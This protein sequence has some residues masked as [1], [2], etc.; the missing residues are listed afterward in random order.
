MAWYIC[1]NWWNNIDILFL[2]KV[3]NRIHSSMVF[4]KYVV[5]CVH[6]QSSIQESFTVLRVPR[7]PPIQ[8]SSFLPQTP[9][10]SHLFTVS[11]VLP[12][13]ECHIDGIIQHVAFP[14]SFFHIAIYIK[15]SSVSFLS[16]YE[17]IVVYFFNCWITFHCLDIPQLMYLFIYWKMSWLLPIFGSYE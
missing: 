6:H 10:S 14:I 2:T 4:T 8:R 11:M 1:N 16:F 9:A 7:T 17:V 12:F 5:S 13:S 3:Y 15:V